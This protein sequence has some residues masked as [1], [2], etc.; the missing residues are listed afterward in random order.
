[1]FRNRI[2]LKSFAVFFILEIIGNVFWPSISYALTAGPTAPEATSFE[3]VDTTDMVNLATGDLAYNI[4]LLEVPGPSGG[5]P[6]SLSYHAG[7]MPNEEASWVGLGWTLNPGAINRNVN[8]FADDHFNAGNVDRFFWKGGETHTLEVGV[9]LGISGVAGV[10]AGLSFSQDTYQGFGVG[11][12]VGGSIGIGGNDSPFG[13]GGSLGVDGYGNPYASAGLNVG[14]NSSESSAVKLGLSIGGSTNFRSV[15]G[16]AAGGASV[17]YNKSGESSGAIQAGSASLL[18]ASI[19]TGKGVGASISAGG[20]SRVHNSKREKVSTSSWGVTLPIPFINLGYRY[21][22]Y[23]IDETENVKTFGSLYNPTEEVDDGFNKK[24]YD[25]YSLVD[26]NKDFFSNPDPEK[27]MG[28]SFLSY[29]NY[30]V[31]AQGLGGYMRPYSYKNLIFRQNQ[32]KN[33]SYKLKQYPYADG[34]RNE[35]IEFRFINDFSNKYINQGGSLA[36]GAP[37][38]IP[39]FGFAEKTG[40]DNSAVD[41]FADGHLYGSRHIEWY[42]N[43]QIL[44][45]DNSKNPEME[46]FI[47]T[48]ATGFTRKGEP[49]LGVIP[50]IGRQIGG[51][52]ITNESGVTYHFA[53][54]VYVFNEYQRSENI[55]NENGKTFNELTKKEPYAYTW[56]LTAITGP[57]FIDRGEIGKLDSED[58]GYWVELE[59][60][61]WTDFYAWRNPSE[62][63]TPDIDGDFRNFSEGLK[64]LYYLDAVRTKTHTALF[65]KSIRY[66]AKGTIY[67]LRDKSGFEEDAKIEVSNITREGGFTP[68]T[69]ENNCKIQYF[70]TAGQGF[71]IDEWD[72]GTITYT[73]RPTSSLKLDSIYLISNSDLSTINFSKNNGVEYSQNYSYSWTVHKDG[74]T[75]NF[76]QCDFSPYISIPHLYQNILDEYDLEIFGASLRSKALRV[77]GFENSYQLTPETE[78]SFDFSLVNIA[79]PSTDEADYPR[80]GKLTLDAI[81]FQGKGGSKLIPPTRFGYELEDPLRGNGYMVQEAGIFNLN[82]FSMSQ[83]SSSLVIGDILKIFSRERV[84]YGLVYEISGGLHKIKILGDKRPYNN[85]YASWELTKNPPYNKDHYDMWGMYKSDFNSADDQSIAKLVTEISSKNTD[86]WSLRSIMPSTGSLIRI[87]Y[88]SDSYKTPALYKF[89]NLKVKSIIKESNDYYTISLYATA[90]VLNNLKIGQELSYNF[91][92]AH[93]YTEID[94]GTCNL[95]TGGIRGQIFS[96]TLVIKEVY[97]DMDKI[98]IKTDSDLSQLFVTRPPYG[99][100]WVSGCEYSMEG[101]YKP[102]LFLA[103][104]ISSL[105]NFENYGGGIRVAG[106]ELKTFNSTTLTEYDYSKNGFGTTGHTSY[107]PGQL[108]QVVYHIPTT[109][110]L[111]TYFWNAEEVEKVKNSYRNKLYQNFSKILANSREVTPPG[112]IYEYVTIREKNLNTESVLELPNSSQYQ[113]EVFTE[114]KVVADSILYPD[115][116]VSSSYG[117]TSYK[118]I[119]RRAVKYKDMTST[120]GQLKRI[121]LFDKDGRKI[122]ET[123]NHYLIDEVIGETPTAKS[124]DYYQKIKDQFKGHGIIEETTM[125]G[126]F[127]KQKNG[128]FHLLGVISRKHAYPSIQTGQT[129]INYKTGITTTTK[130]LAFDFYSGQVTKTLSTDGYGNSYVTET[131][132][133]YRVAEYASGMGVA[134]S[135]GKNMLTQE[136]ASYT[137]KADVTDNLKPIG[138]ISA[139][140]QTWS[141]QISAVKPNENTSQY[142]HQ[143]GI[144]RK[145]ATYGYIGDD[146]TA[147]QSDGLYP[148]AGNSLPVFTSWADVRGVEE[149][150]PAGWQRNGEITLYDVNS[151]ALEA[152]DMSNKY[153]ATKMSADQTKVLATIANAE[154]LEFAYSGAEEIPGTNGLVGGGV[155]LQGSRVE[156]AHTG[157]YGISA[158]AGNTAFTYSM[159]PKQRNYLVSVWSSQPDAQ[160]TYKL[161][162]GTTVQ[163]TVKK[164]G[165]AGDWYNLQ[166]IVP[167][168]GSWNNLEI[169]CQSKT[170]TTVFDDFRVQPVD[171]AMISYVYNEWDEL[172]HILDNNNLYTEYVYDGMGRLKETKKETLYKEEGDTDG[173]R[174]GS[175]GVVKVSEVDYNY[176]AKTPYTTTITA[177]KSGPSGALSQ[178]GIITVPQG[179]QLMIEVRETCTYNRLQSIMIDGVMIN[180]SQPTRTLVD[181]TQVILNGKVVTFKNIQSPHTLNA[182]FMTSPAGWVRCYTSVVNGVTCYDGSLE[183]GY[184]NNCGQE[185]VMGRVMDASYLPPDMQQFAPAYPCCDNTGGPI[186]LQNQSIFAPQVLPPD[187]NP[188]PCEAN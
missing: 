151:H 61:K 169:K 91:L 37:P 114:D 157:K 179:G 161:G 150:V 177:S 7:I 109:G 40:D 106:I 165:K 147:L 46:G 115:I 108:E 164:I 182:T 135:G 146:N 122:N 139:S 84:C 184:Y 81:H 156:Q 62:G 18:G 188:C 39:L 23:W 9:T 136:A 56:Y 185:M 73:A 85:Q 71:G 123:I 63:M 33:D 92:Y 131:K 22:R 49:V 17:G 8:G 77:I 110:S 111:A 43:A 140:V 79:I 30:S 180:A 173:H 178:S 187:P 86:V 74:S 102:P 138:L 24:A 29:D 154:Y 2:F 66:D 4:P 47:D 54:P 134:A 181:G 60:G 83:A 168:T 20:V 104:N 97:T 124:E 90:S 142:Q 78:N 148:L 25:S 116:S 133:A 64:E 10:S 112:V 107:E 26:P 5:Y 103:G 143:P 38:L 99:E 171:A 88:E 149:I 100:Y 57:D 1:M 72:D 101:T 132:P 176:G 170:T 34:Y 80:H 48:R 12:S 42:T 76:E 65:A 13:V 144:W 183:Y 141:D 186:P 68:K 158:T 166:T 35:A 155:Y 125:D 45:H 89:S 163:G 172:S 3:P 128:D 160:I 15:S 152:K 82:K 137:Y 75:N 105:N 59:Y 174:Y 69:V 120:V 145:H 118:K 70:R 153:A 28:G 127:V 94:W 113:F 31:N 27:V 159:T 44:N 96:N 50:P 32:K 52:K 98:V 117:G 19:S 167:V 41:G 119:R 55:S 93:P 87:A 51:F 130:N 95:S 162:S 36:S 11:F 121:T 6:L 58:W 14:L 129:V 16:Y 67:A 126:R 53:L 175:S 21:Q